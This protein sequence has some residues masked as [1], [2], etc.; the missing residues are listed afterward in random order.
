MEKQYRHFTLEDRCTIARLREGGQSIRQIAATMDRA[1]SSISR[2]IKRNTCTTI[3]YRPAYAN[4]LAV[5]RRWQGSRMDRDPVLRELVLNQLKTGWSPEQISGRLAHDKATIRISYESIY[6]FIHRQIRRHLDYSWRHYLPRGK[7]QRGYTRRASKP[8]EHFKKRVPITKRARYIEHRRQVGHWEADLLHL[9]KFGA[10]VLVNVERSSRFV[11][12]AKQK[13]KHSAL[14]VEQLQQWFGAM[15]PAMRRTLAMDNGTEFFLHHQ[16]HA[17]G[18]KTYFCKPHSPWQKGSVENM[19]GRIRRYI[20]RSTEPNSFDNQDLQALASKLNTTP[21]K[22]LG[23]KTPAEVFYKHLQPLHFKCEFTH[24]FFI[25]GWRSILQQNSCNTKSIQPF[26]NLSALMRP[27][28]KHVATAWRN[29]HRSTIGL[30][31]FVN[32]DGW[33]KHIRNAI[34]P[35]LAIRINQLLGSFRL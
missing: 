26:A 34:G 15:P 18:I 31:R 29:N 27:R 32:C 24:F 21:R 12:L 16:L 30:C 2:E 14:V 33:F 7:G 13:S 3:G 5:S 10:T 25:P 6:R 35:G 4:D 19:N 22:C 11:M 17:C 20:P 9:S 23:F 1:T 28:K 8:I